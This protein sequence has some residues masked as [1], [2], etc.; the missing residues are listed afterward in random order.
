MVM[1]IIE[2]FLDKGYYVF[3]DNYYYTSV[4]L[5]EVLEKKNS[6]MCYSE[7]QQIWSIKRICGVKEKKVKQFKRG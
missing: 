1:S 3:M 6:S 5:F 4:T 2:P 7:V